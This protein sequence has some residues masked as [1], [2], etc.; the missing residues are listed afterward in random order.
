MKIEGERERRSVKLRIKRER[1]RGG[2]RGKRL[3]LSQI[4]RKGE[5]YR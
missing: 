3:I 1:K 2:E 5:R 4:R